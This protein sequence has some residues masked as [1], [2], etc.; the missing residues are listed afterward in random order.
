MFCFKYWVKNLANNP[1]RYVL[2][3]GQHS[4]RHTL[5]DVFF[6]LQPPAHNYGTVRMIFYFTDNHLSWFDAGFK[7][8][9][10]YMA[11]WYAVFLQNLLGGMK[12]KMAIGIPPE[13]LITPLLAPFSFEFFF[14]SNIFTCQQ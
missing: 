1:E 13:M 4:I 12:V 8:Q 7:L 14:G 3:I 6:F 11:G 2:N 10:M 9:P 5:K